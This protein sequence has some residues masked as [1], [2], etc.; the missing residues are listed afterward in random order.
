VLPSEARCTACESLMLLQAWAVV[1]L[2][3]VDNED[4]LVCGCRQVSRSDAWRA[5]AISNLYYCPIKKGVG[6]RS[7]GIPS[8]VLNMVRHGVVGYSKE[9]FEHVSS[10]LELFLRKVITKQVGFDQFMVKRVAF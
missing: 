5:N 2:P 10:H 3:V 8:L 4:Y 9:P 6:S 1:E 7:D